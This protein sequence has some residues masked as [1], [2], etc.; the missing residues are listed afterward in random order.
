MIEKLT[1]R[2]P[3]GFLNINE[4]YSDDIENVD[5]LIEEI[6]KIDQKNFGFTKRNTTN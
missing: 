1:R 3:G 5:K 2:F 6:E 4:Y